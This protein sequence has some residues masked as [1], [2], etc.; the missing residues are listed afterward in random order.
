MIFEIKKYTHCSS[1]F[2]RSWRRRSCSNYLV[3]VKL[4]FFFK[5]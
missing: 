4:F 5:L 2:C 3:M 1:W